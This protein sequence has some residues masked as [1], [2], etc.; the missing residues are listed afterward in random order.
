[1]SNYLLIY[2]A[3]ITL[4]KIDFIKSV[5]KFSIEINNEIYTL[6]HDEIN[7][8]TETFELTKKNFYICEDTKDCI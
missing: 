2:L 8:T 1:M 7:N 5:I 3:I 6:D 4:Y